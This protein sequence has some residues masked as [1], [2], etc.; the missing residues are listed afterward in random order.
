MDLFNSVRIQTPESVELEFTLAGVG[1]RG[2]ALIIDYI[3]LGGMLLVSFWLWLLALTQLSEWDTVLSVDTDTLELWITAISSL[4]AFALYVGYFVGF[5]TIWYGQTPGKR[6]SKIR[7]S[8]ETMASRCDYFRPHCAQSLAQLTTFYS[9][10]S[11]AFYSASAK[12]EL[13]TG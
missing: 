5:E 1:S 6:Y 2:V 4:L 3:V 12:S 7:V 8:F 13:A 9:W 10:A 11:F